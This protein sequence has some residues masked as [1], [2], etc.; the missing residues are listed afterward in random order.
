MTIA[1]GAT[2]S[3]PF[4]LFAS[5]A[6]MP[7]TWVPWPFSS[8]G[9]SSF[10]CWTKSRPATSRP[11]RSS[12]EA[13]TPVSITAT[14]TPEPVLVAWAASAW[15]MSSPHCWDRSGSFEAA[16]AVA[17]TASETS[18]ATRNASEV[19]MASVS[20]TRPRLIPLPGANALV[21]NELQYVARAAAEGRGCLGRFVRADEV[22]R[23]PRVVG[24]RH[25]ALVAA[26]APRLV[27]QDLEERGVASPGV[28]AQQHHRAAAADPVRVLRR[29]LE[30]LLR[31]ARTSGCE[32]DAGDRDRDEAV[33]ADRVGEVL[34]DVGGELSD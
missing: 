7:V 31:G 12:C 27:A 20:P 34:G 1:S 5:A 4:P 25:K 11:A 15:I 22:E 17:V 3:M 18:R 28:A 32:H 23:F 9:V 30:Q 19:R 6:T 26:E 21:L 8:C 33:L 14:T 13:S 24:E 29:V 10:G 2:P 16:E